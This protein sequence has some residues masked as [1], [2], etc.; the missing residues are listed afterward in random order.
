MTHCS[1]QF[2]IFN[3]RKQTILS[4]V[5]STIICSRQN[6]KQHYNFHP[7]I[8]NTVYEKVMD[9]KNRVHVYNN[10]INEGD[11]LVFFSLSVIIEDVFFTDF[12]TFKIR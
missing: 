2:V 8:M 11:T 6:A 4:L 3:D 12:C 9:V 5:L 10:I 7:K 1:T